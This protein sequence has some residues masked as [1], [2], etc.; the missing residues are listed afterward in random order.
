[1][2]SNTNLDV[3]KELIKQLEECQKITNKNF[4]IIG[5]G[6]KESWLTTILANEIFGIQ[7]VLAVNIYST[8]SNSILP[9]KIASIC[10]M[11]NFQYCDVDITN[12]IQETLS[13]R[14]GL[15]RIEKE[16]LHYMMTDLQKSEIIS[17]IRNT[18]L[19]G[20]SDRHDG[21]LLT[22]ISLSKIISGWVSPVV[23]MFDWNPLVKCTYNQVQLTIKDYNMGLEILDIPSGLDLDMRGG[24]FPTD[25]NIDFT[26]DDNLEKINKNINIK[27]LGVGIYQL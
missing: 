13:S 2:K 9:H 18:V 8:F 5:L 19:R 23:S 26:N 4:Y 17:M 6:G 3:K 24:P 27:N 21:V 14:I 15:F 12:A 1:M 20:I 7:N 10:Q 16:K 22:G 25:Y 11:Y